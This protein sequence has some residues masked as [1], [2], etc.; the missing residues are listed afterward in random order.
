MRHT[1]LACA[2]LSALLLAACTS[3]GTLTLKDHLKNPLFAE[4]YAEAMVDRLVEMEITKDP[5]LETPSVQ[6][7]LDS[8]RQLWLQIARDARHMEGNLIPM[9]E[10]AKGDVLY[11]PGSLY[12]G[13]LFEVDP[14][15]S[16]HI[17]LTTVVDPRDVTFPDDTA[18]DLGTLQSAYGPQRYAVPKVDNPLLYRTVV[19][20]DTVFNRLHSF[21]QLSK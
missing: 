4:R 11:V 18:M 16:L 6:E 10:F 15:P 13:T 8:E 21:A 14:L 2:S 17:Y 9:G 20:W 12:F 1:T 3:S 5:S 19:L 7:R